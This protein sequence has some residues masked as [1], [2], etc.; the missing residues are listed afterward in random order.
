[1]YVQDRLFSLVEQDDQQK[2]E[3]IFRSKSAFF[4]SNKTET[5]AFIIFVACPILKIQS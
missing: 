3:S 1:M 4:F 5:F 2:P